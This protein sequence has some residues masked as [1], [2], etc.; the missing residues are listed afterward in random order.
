M[1][2]LSGITDVLSNPTRMDSDIGVTEH[3]LSLRKTNAAHLKYDTRPFY[4]IV[5]IVTVK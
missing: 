4:S 2:R 5:S 3:I 1:T